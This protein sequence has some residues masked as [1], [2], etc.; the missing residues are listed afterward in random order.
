MKKLFVFVF[1]I[2]AVTSYAKSQKLYIYNWS[3]Y[4]PDEV[5]AQFQK[6]TGIKV[7][8]STYDSN[9]AMY[10]KV[11]IATSAYDI[12][13]PS[14]Y[15]VN[16][17]RKEGKLHKIDK[18]KIPNLKNIDPS[19]L[20]QNYDKGNEYSVPYLWGSTA[21][22]VNSDRIALSKVKSFKDLWKPEFKNQV[23]LTN[24]MREVFAVGLMT[25]G[26]SGNSTNP[27]EIKEAYENLKK[28]LPNVRLFSSESQKEPFLNEEV[29]LGLAWN[30]EAYV[31]NEENPALKYIY[32]T[33][34]AILWL[35]SMVIPKNA[36]NVDAAH[37]FINFILRPE[38]GKTITQ[39]IGYTSPNKE[40]IKLLDKKYRNNKIVF[41]DKEVIEKGEFQLDVGETILIYE[42]YWE[43]LKANR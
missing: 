20:D 4:M 8:Y 42:K 39:E 23:I 25:L 14:T 41:P 40:S 9:E 17:M 34:G 21:I 36:K 2:I 19:L 27:Q 37:K 7:I 15:Y 35:D 29:T 38:I 1:I 31:A 5:I 11:N 16:R 12:I 22:M 26:Y 33:E 32:P 10:S 43:K 3:E 13:F 6:E 30:G 24:D 28:L 18:S